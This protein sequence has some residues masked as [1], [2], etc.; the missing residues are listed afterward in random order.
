[1]ESFL[2]LKRSFTIFFLT[3]MLIVNI[4]VCYSFLL[5]LWLNIN[6]LKA[7]KIKIHF[8]ILAVFN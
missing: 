8:S 1:M 6:T 7:I 2:G 4:M 3:K 5:Q